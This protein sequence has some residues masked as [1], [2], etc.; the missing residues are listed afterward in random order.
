MV[1]CV[2]IAN[3]FFVFMIYYCPLRQFF[4]AM[5]RMLQKYTQMIRI[6]GST[7]SSNYNNNN[8]KSSLMIGGTSRYYSNNNNNINNNNSSSQLPTSA[9][10]D[11]EGT[12]PRSASLRKS[13][14]NRASN[15]FSSRHA[16]SGAD[17]ANLS[18]EEK[19]RRRRR[20]K[21]RKAQRRS[22]ANQ[23]DGSARASSNGE[24]RTYYDE[25][26]DEYF[27]SDEEEDFLSGGNANMSQSDRIVGALVE[28]IQL[29]DMEEHKMS[30]AKLLE[31]A[32]SLLRDRAEKLAEIA[33]LEKKLLSG[34]GCCDGGGD[35]STDANAGSAKMP[36]LND[37]PHRP[38][39]VL[40]ATQARQTSG[41]ASAFRPTY[42]Y[43][44]ASNSQNHNQIRDQNSSNNHNNNNNPDAIATIT[45]STV[46]A[47]SRSNSGQSQQQHPSPPSRN[48][49]DIHM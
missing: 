44:S 18:E 35:A 32:R 19:K 5:E 10:V 17:E 30:G 7:T 11:I 43:Y 3:A 2:A 20:S 8:N 41:T 38:A 15:S 16:A 36:T 25:V 1:P 24:T 13:C 9:M 46:T 21:I 47:R 27:F 14:A 28:C 6:R 39:S 31:R 23:K 22:S 48:P 37:D 40:S 26:D 45:S 12:R 42:Y 4:Y 34:S 33:R 29:R 49:I